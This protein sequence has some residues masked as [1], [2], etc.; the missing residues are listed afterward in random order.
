MD[1]VSDFIAYMNK[2][3]ACD[4]RN[5]KTDSKVIRVLTVKGK[6]QLCR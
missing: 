2:N 1:S 5:K 3:V 4:P 6:K